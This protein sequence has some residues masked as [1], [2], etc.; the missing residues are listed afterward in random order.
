ML[1]LVRPPTGLP[2]VAAFGPGVRRAL[3]V[4]SGHQPDISVSSGASAIVHR[5]KLRLNLNDSGP[6]A[7][8]DLD[9]LIDAQLRA[10]HDGDVEGILAAMDDAV[11]HDLVG[12][13]E[14]PIQ[15]LEA[16]RRRYHDLLAAT[17]HERDVPLRRLYGRDF[18][19]DEHVWSGR[20]TGRAF[21]IDGHGRS[22]SHRVLWLV[23]VRDGRIVRE[24]VWNDLVAIRRQL[25]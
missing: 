6:S 23:E 25:E 3:A 19:L 22:L 17:V 12:A 8:A 13:T 24:T 9:R 20:L 14:N 2:S 5:V 10:E 4:R 7:Q 11:V 15:G 16:V 1:F 21:E 18:V